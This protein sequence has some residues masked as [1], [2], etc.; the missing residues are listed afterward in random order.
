MIHSQSP[1]T[2]F[3]SFP[4]EM[5]LDDPFLKLPVID[6]LPCNFFTAMVW[7]NVGREGINVNIEFTTNWA[8]SVKPFI[9]LYT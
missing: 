8:T 1:L 4:P 2:S 5:G 9:V 3:D 6:P 7:S